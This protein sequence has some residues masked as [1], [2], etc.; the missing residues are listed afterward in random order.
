MGIAVLLAVELGDRRLEVLA[1]S[2]YYRDP[3]LVAIENNCRSLRR[4][5]GICL[6]RMYSSGEIVSEDVDCQFEIRISERVR[7]YVYWVFCA[8]RRTRGPA[9]IA[10]AEVVVEFVV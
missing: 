8:V 5:N 6:N 4:E 10:I 2:P 9:A 7:S 1:A 3:V